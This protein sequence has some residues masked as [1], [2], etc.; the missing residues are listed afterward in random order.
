M[1]QTNKAALTRDFELPSGNIF[2]GALNIVHVPRC[3][4]APP[5]AVVL[6]PTPIVL[7][8]GQRAELIAKYE[9]LGY[10]NARATAFADSFDTPAFMTV[11]TWHGKKA[12][13]FSRSQAEM[14][15]ASHGMSINDEKGV[16][17][18]AIRLFKE[19]N[20]SAAIT[21]DNIDSL[22][23]HPLI[24]GSGW[25]IIAPLTIGMP[26]NGFEICYPK[27]FACDG[28]YQGYQM[29]AT[30]RTYFKDNST[31]WVYCSVPIGRSGVKFVT[32]FLKRPR[33]VHDRDF[34][35]SG[36]SPTNVDR[37]TNNVYVL[38][39][40]YGNADIPTAYMATIG[41]SG[42]TNEKAAAM[43]AFGGLSFTAGVKSVL[44]TS[45]ETDWPGWLDEEVVAAVS[46]NGNNV[47]SKYMFAYGW[48]DA[49]RV[50][51]WQY[52]NY[53]DIVEGD[54]NIRTINPLSSYYGFEEKQ[55]RRFLTQLIDSGQYSGSDLTELTNARMS[56][57][58]VAENNIH[59]VCQPGG[60]QLTQDLEST[61]DLAIKAEDEGL[62]PR[63]IELSN[64]VTLGTIADQARTRAKINAM[65][66]MPK[67]DQNSGLFGNEIITFSGTI[68]PTFIVNQNG[69]D[70]EA[71][72]EE[73]MVATGLGASWVL[74]G[75][76]EAQVA[77]FYFGVNTKAEAK[78]L[79]QA[80]DL[81]IY[82]DPKYRFDDYS[83][84][85]R[86]DAWDVET[87]SEKARIT[88]NQ[89]LGDRES[90][91]YM[92]LS[93]SS[94]SLARR[95]RN[96][97]VSY[98]EL[99]DKEAAKIGEITF[100][101][102]R[103]GWALNKARNIRVSNYNSVIK[104][105][106]AQSNNYH[107][108]ALPNKNSKAAFSLKFLTLDSGDYYGVGLDSDLSN[109]FRPINTANGAPQVAAFDFGTGPGGL[110]VN[111]VMT[112][113]YD[114]TVVPSTLRFYKNGV[115]YGGWNIPGTPLLRPFMRFDYV[116]CSV[117][118]DTRPAWKPAG[119]NDWDI[120]V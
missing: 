51:V 96:T 38:A 10:S 89:L 34:V 50:C 70:I 47:I 15:I 60:F 69:A 41:V 32:L 95:L 65:C 91:A 105:I 92:L 110:V 2:Q 5:Q 4:V 111:D 112:F 61:L 115:F 29:D 25:E 120:E 94:W 93:M 23:D 45:L 3:G 28:G 84:W 55:L 107:W 59:V 16:L 11:G 86:Y 80:Q 46:A 75:P 90:T 30:T 48:L 22:C 57:A 117:Q 81:S 73:M 52:D 31:D 100:V 88:V 42:A 26:N 36:I 13:A 82:H 119:Y 44:V 116:G 43:D 77:M 103:S 66:F 53:V 85:Y 76:T 78:T 6:S 19:F 114:T 64:A 1:L 102:P 74:T 87:V 79:M 49:P 12:I 7:T 39:K 24:R 72:E 33:T 113:A 9:A 17:R 35:F 67:D 99:V 98:A 54:V 20:L 40:G 83:C 62:D 106:V 27:Y 21:A 56:L 37:A 101:K 8:T 14:P 109:Y 68:S 118:L 63:D 104:P 108:G 58:D 71:S 18:Q 97:Y